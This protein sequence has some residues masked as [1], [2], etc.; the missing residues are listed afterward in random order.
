MDFQR[1]RRKL[2]QHLEVLTAGVA[3]VFVQRH[4]AIVILAVRWG[5]GGFGSFG[6][7]ILHSLIRC[8]DEAMRTTVDLDEAL[9]RTV[10]DIAAA[11]RQTFSRVIAE[12]AWK[13]LEP[14]KQDR[15]TRNGF[16]LLPPR[17]GARTVTPEHVADLLEQADLAD[18]G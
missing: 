8:Y 9:L 2:L 5:R 1:G 11:R 17:P 14:D 3:L 13:G 4:N 15:T 7:D 12:L 10:K 16:A 6:G 18:V